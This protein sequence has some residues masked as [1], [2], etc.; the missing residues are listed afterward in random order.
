[1]NVMDRFSQSNEQR[2]EMVEPDVTKLEDS[3]NA[4]LNRNNLL[5]ATMAHANYLHMHAPGMNSRFNDEAMLRGLIASRDTS[6][7]EELDFNDLLRQRMILAERARLELLSK[8]AL[9]NSQ[10]VMTH[11]GMPPTYCLDSAD[12]GIDRGTR[13]LQS[14]WAGGPPQKKS[15]KDKS[16]S[17]V[18][19]LSDAERKATFPLPLMKETKERKVVG[20]LSFFRKTWARLERHSDRMDDTT[21]DQDAFVKEF[22]QRSLHSYKSDHLKK[23]V[24]DWSESKC[25]QE[26]V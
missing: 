7:V 5:S 11:P 24:R 13:R 23:R 12:A 17:I 19:S 4:S 8:V 22:F 15:R 14:L 20:K 18:M 3:E 6:G 9:I 10:N 26:E 25:G 2:R 16:S 1:M 21:A